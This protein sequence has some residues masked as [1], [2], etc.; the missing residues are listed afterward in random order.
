[1]AGAFACARRIAADDGDADITTAGGASPESFTATGCANSG[2]SCDTDSAT[3][4]SRDGN[5]GPRTSPGDCSTACD[6]SELDCAHSNAIANVASSAVPDAVGSASSGAGSGVSSTHRAS[7]DPHSTDCDADGDTDGRADTSGIA[8]PRTDARP[9][10]HA[11]DAAA[12]ADADADA[13]AGLCARDGDD[14]GGL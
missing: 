8:E 7:P 9:S 12:A 11:D 10:A 14:R 6:T 3:V 13:D 2:A 4:A 5:C 1:M